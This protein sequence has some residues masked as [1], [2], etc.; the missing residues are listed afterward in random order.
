MKLEEFKEKFYVEFTSEITN[1]EIK[2]KSSL[3][4]REDKVEATYY[5][6]SFNLYELRRIIIDSHFIS[7]TEGDIIELIKRQHLDNI[8]RVLNIPDFYPI[9]KDV[10]INEFY[11]N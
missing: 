6:A 10:D 9:N 2:Y 4:N 11:Q 1:D 8:V 3:I 5:I 7:Y